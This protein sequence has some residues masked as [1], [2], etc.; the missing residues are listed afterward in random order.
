MVG[1]ALLRSDESGASAVHQAA[2]ADPGRGPTVLTRAFSGRPA[3]GLQNTFTEKYSE[4]A[5][6]GYPALHHLT[7]GLRKAATAAGN[8]EL[9]HLWAGTGYRNATT[10]PAATILT[11]LAS[12]V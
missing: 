1:T 2:I 8:P 6:L 11:R 3:R 7:S 9:A 4:L 5:P 10:G 12:A